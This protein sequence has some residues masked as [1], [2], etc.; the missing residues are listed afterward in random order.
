MSRT[1]KDRP[2][3][4]RFPGPHDFELVELDGN[5]VRWAQI[6]GRCAKKPRR[7]DTKYHWQTTPSHWT[8]TMMIRPRRHRENQQLRTLHDLENFDFVDTKR[9][10]HI[11]YW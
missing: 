10:P 11:Y 2:T 1:Y 9:K 7:Q 5:W 4:I 3:R 8:Y 6:P